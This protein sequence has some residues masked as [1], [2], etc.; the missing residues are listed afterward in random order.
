M[1]AALTERGSTI[2]SVQGG[3]REGGPSQVLRAVEGP[4]HAWWGRGWT[5]DCR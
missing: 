2:V 4:V 5:T 1:A 3:L